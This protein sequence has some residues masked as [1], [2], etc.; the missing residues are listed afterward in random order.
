MENV[1]TMTGTTSVVITTVPNSRDYISH[2][3]LP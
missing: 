1:A 2:L 3:A